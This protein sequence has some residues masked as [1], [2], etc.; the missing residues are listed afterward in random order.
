MGIDVGKFFQT[1]TLGFVSVASF[2]EFMQI[3]TNVGLIELSWEE[4]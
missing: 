2:A 1:L 3:L 4:I